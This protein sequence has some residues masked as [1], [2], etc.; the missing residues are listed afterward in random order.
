MNSVRTL[1]AM[2]PRA[3]AA[4]GNILRISSAV[5]YLGCAVFGY[6][7]IQ[8]SQVGAP[9]DFVIEHAALS[10]ASFVF[11]IL[12]WNVKGPLVSGNFIVRLLVGLYML[13]WIISTLG[14][15][16]IFIGIVYLFTGE[17]DNSEVF[18]KGKAPKPRFKPLAEWRATGRVGPSGATL[19]ADPYRAAPAGIFD[20]W[21]PVQV[22]DK[23]DGYAKVVAATGEGGWIDLRTLT[24]GV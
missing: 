23:R 17:P 10:V 16:L 19:Y 13:F 5:S 24:D 21:T 8:L 3:W 7:A 4:I 11:A 14:F 2:G 22:M 1:V 20:S 9:R 12:L 18:K 15:G 6:R